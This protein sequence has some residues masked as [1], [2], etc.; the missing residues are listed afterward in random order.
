[1]HHGD[2]WLSSPEYTSEITV[3]ARIPSI[4]MSARVERPNF[5]AGFTI[6]ASIAESRLLP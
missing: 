1:M 5:S 3:H 2:D 6:N 4:L